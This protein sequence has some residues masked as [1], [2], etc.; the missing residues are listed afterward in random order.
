MEIAML[1]LGIAQ[2]SWAAA[3]KAGLVGDPNWD[4]SINLAA[5]AMTKAIGIVQEIKGGA[6][7]Y[8]NMTDAQIRALLLPTDLSVLERQVA[9]ELGFA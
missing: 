9:A 8:D 7:A 6:T 1:I 2:A 3:V 4:T 5:V